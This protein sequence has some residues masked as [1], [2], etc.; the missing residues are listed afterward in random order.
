[1]VRGRGHFSYGAFLALAAIPVFWVLPNVCATVLIENFTGYSAAD[2]AG[3]NGGS[4]A[5]SSAWTQVSGNIN[6]VTGSVGSVSTITSTDPFVQ[7]TLAGPADTYSRTFGTL[8]GQSNIYFSVL[9]N[10]QPPANSQGGIDFYNGGDEQFDFGKTDGG[11]TRWGITARPGTGGFA[12]GNSSVA[13]LNNTT[14]LLVGRIDQV[15]S[16]ATLWVN[17][18]LTLQEA[19]NTAAL[20]LTNGPGD[21]SIDRVRLRADGNSGTVWQFDNLTI[22]S[23]GSSPFGATVAAVPEPAVTTLFLLG[24]VIMYRRRK[25]RRATETCSAAGNKACRFRA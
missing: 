12:S 8:S 13:I 15:N 9:L 10:I 4:G 24:A 18:V 14:T 5:W 21:T 19:D 11:S 2:L 3:D 25:A 7:A 16:I 6:V 22:Y 1:M 17:P 23:G 20:T